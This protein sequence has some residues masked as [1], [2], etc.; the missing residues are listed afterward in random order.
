MDER[1]RLAEA[2]RLLSRLAER[3]DSS[4][5]V[6]GLAAAAFSRWCAAHGR[7]AVWSEASL[8]AYLEAQ[9]RDWRW[10]YATRVVDSLR[11]EAKAAGHPNPVG[12]TVRDRLAG[13]GRREGEELIDAVRVR[14]LGPMVAA[15]A[16]PAEHVAASAS[17]VAAHLVCAAALDQAVPVGQPADPALPPDVALRFRDGDVRL[18]DGAGR[19]TVID[20][21]SSAFRFAVLAEARPYLEATDGLPARARGVSV[22]SAV[23]RAGYGTPKLFWP[24]HFGDADLA[25]L[26][27]NLVPDLAR[28]RRDSAYLV[29]GVLLA[30]RHRDLSYH[31]DL[32]NVVTAPEGYRLRLTSSKNDPGGARE[33]HLLPH[34][35]SAE[36]TGVPCG[37]CVF[38]AHLE[39][40]AASGRTSGPVF[41]TR[42]AGRWRAMTRQS[43][44]HIVRSAW[45]K[46]ALPDG[47]RLGTRSMRVGGATSAWE[48]G[49]SY[50]AIAADLTRHECASQ[51]RLYVRAPAQGAFEL[52][53]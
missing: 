48:S 16:R 47:L 18:H 28:R 44:R 34:T 23:R 9:G 20:P 32:E 17:V 2:M 1:V 22:R 10:S 7:S 51:A 21:T 31:L 13:W 4:R 38:A 42:Y 40:V 6:D 15:L 27:A 29:T 19:S 12:P 35:H 33:P 52:R 43:G 37:A 39:C 46:A 25:W 8:L 5:E 14:D 45:A 41:A 30:L 49:L 36:V 50:V 3:A 53:L 26:C 24:A 11:H